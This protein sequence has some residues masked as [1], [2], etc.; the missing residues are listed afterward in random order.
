MPD[1]HRWTQIF[2]YWVGS[3]IPKLLGIWSP[4]QTRLKT[5]A[6]GARF[7]S[8]LNVITYI[9]NET[10]LY[11]INIGIL[12]L[13]WSQIILNIFLSRSFFVDIFV[14]QKKHLDSFSYQDENYLKPPLPSTTSQIRKGTYHISLEFVQSLCDT[15][16]GLVDIF[17][18][19]D[20]KKAL[21][22][23]VKHFFDI[24]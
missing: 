15:S 16:Y 9:L 20:R 12:F 7:P 13:F 19:E 24:F 10:I 11:R 8:R 1:G 14:L 18:V 3:Q 2:R 22:E 4:I 6:C 5:I 23:V 21:N 17:P